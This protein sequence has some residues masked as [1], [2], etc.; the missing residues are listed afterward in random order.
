MQENLHKI[1]SDC[2]SECDNLTKVKSKIYNRLPDAYLCK[3]CLCLMDDMV[4]WSYW[5]AEPYLDNGKLL[6]V[7]QKRRNKTG[8]PR[9]NTS[10]YYENY[11]DKKQREGLTRVNW[12][13][14]S[15]DLQD[16]NQLIVDK[17]LKSIAEALNVV[18]RK[19]F[20]KKK[21]NK[22]KNIEIKD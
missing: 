5:I 3:A 13:V 14:F 20:K 22:I 7:M 4:D 19:Y 6:K 15:E 17:D 9:S 11:I 16:L 8:V 12:F 21:E 1:C 18:C 2:L 10:E